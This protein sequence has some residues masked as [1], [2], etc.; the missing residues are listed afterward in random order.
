M[1]FMQCAFFRSRSR[2]RSLSYYLFHSLSLS[3]TLSFSHYL[4]TLLYLNALCQLRFSVLWSCLGNKCKNCAQIIGA[5]KLFLFRPREGAIIFILRIR[6]VVRA[7]PS[8]RNNVLR[9]GVFHC[10][11]VYN[12]S[13]TI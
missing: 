9:C 10:N 12:L 1:H 13:T 3:L 5:C 7:C 6:S 11:R 2:S 8:P 4:C